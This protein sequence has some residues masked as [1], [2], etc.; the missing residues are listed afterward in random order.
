MRPRAETGR[1]SR[2]AGLALLG[3]VCSSAS[4]EQTVKGRVLEADDI[5]RVWIAA[6]EA[7]PPKAEWTL[8]EDGEFE[9]PALPVAPTDLVAVAKDRVPLAIP[10]PTG[11]QGRQLELRLSQGL[12]LEGSVRSEYGAPLRGVTIRAVRADT[13]VHDTLGR[14][15][16][17]VRYKMPRSRSVPMTV[18]SSRCRPPSDRLGTQI[19]TARFASLG[20]PPV[21]I[22]SK[23][24]R[25]ATY[26][27][28]GRPQFGRVGPTGSTWCSRRHSSWPAT[29]LMR[30]AHRLPEQR[31][32]RTGDSRTRP[33][34]IA[35][36][37]SAG[38]VGGA[39]W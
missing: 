20:W 12:A 21:G 17:A 32:L 8:V 10:F 33:R 34:R 15:G 26:L 36:N 18:V 4:G 39:R 27:S 19:G 9:L 13:V 35:T 3:A 16:F 38:R 30:Q 1:A 23:F 6:V 5:G 37:R 2:L 25:R 11:E 31:S 29:W 22:C 7:D 24:R 14:A 28:F